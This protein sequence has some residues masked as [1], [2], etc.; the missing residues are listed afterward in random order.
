MN[1]QKRALFTQAM[2]CT[3]TLNI[4]TPTGIKQIEIDE[5][6]QFLCANFDGFS[7]K[8]KK[9]IKPSSNPRAR[10]HKA[11]EQADLRGDNIHFKHLLDGKTK[12]DER[13][14]S[15][16]IEFLQYYIRNTQVCWKLICNATDC[17]L[18]ATKTCSKCHTA[19]YCSRSC[20]VKDWKAGHKMS[21]ESLINWDS[22]A[23]IRTCES[24][25]ES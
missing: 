25:M 17:I 14:D 23:N 10:C 11:L 12:H 2:S 5:L 24:V 16:Q 20:Q 9:F 19:R 18:P 22:S 13:V 6:T 7:S 4:L 8:W 3:Q 21:C 1:E 15:D